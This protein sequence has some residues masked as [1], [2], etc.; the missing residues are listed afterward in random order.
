MRFA[1][2]PTS[3]EPVDFA[4]FSRILVCDLL[5]TWLR[6]ASRLA[7]MDFAGPIAARSCHIAAHSASTS[8]TYVLIKVVERSSFLLLWI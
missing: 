5:S 3:C 7:Y 8:D 2:P 1:T 6:R 4:P